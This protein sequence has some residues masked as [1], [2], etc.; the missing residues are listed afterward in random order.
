MT[1]EEKP[2]PVLVHRSEIKGR[3]L[4]TGFCPF[5]IAYAFKCCKRGVHYDG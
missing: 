4:S 1:N 5:I 3:K 2:A